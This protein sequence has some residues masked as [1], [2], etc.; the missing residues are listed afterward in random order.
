M[1]ILTIRNVPDA[2]H[3][4]LTRERTRRGLPLNQTLIDLLRERLGVGVGHSNG[5]GRLAQQGVDEQFREF[6]K[7]TAAFEGIDEQLW[8]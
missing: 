8:R 3:E 4:A 7:A 2:L 5:L 1:K 6:E